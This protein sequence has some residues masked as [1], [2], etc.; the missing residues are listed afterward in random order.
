MVVGYVAGRLTPVASPDRPVARWAA[1][2]RWSAR[3]SALSGVLLARSR[4]PR[5]RAA[6]GRGRRAGLGHRAAPWSSCRWWYRALRK[7]QQT[8]P[9]VTRRA[10]RPTAP[11]RA[12]G[13][14][15]LAVPDPARPALV[16]PGLSGEAYPAQAAEQSV[17]EIVV[18]PHRGLIV[19]D[20]A[21]RWSPTA[22]A[23]WSASTAP[24]PSSPRRATELLT[25]S[26]GSPT[27]RSR[28]SGRCSPPAATEEGTCW[29]GSPY[30]PVP[31]AVD[32]PQ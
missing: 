14:D 13:A 31:V 21:G 11:V 6:A 4:R 15:A 12:P 8:G 25:G 19:D 20:G 2:A 3:R 22:P 9:G 23:G 30:Q 24:C 7:G 17:R 16:P 28:G 18:Q 5:G 29:N 10:P 27:P 1:A 26:P 32:V